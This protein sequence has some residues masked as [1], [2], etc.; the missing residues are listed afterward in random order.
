MVHRVKSE[1]SSPGA[2]ES[3]LLPPEQAADLRAAI[4]AAEQ[5][6]L[7]SPEAFLRWLEGRGDE[8]DSAPQQAEI[9]PRRNDS[10]A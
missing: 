2:S 4:D 7:L 9:Q 8:L 10:G 1:T 3:P 6:A 5:S